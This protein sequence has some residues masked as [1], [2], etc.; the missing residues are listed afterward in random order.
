MFGVNAIWRSIRASSDQDLLISPG[1]D[2]D[3]FVLAAVV[4]ISDANDE[5]LE[6]LG[7]SRSS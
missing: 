4:S 2:L 7:V 1:V 5:G 6:S 3:G